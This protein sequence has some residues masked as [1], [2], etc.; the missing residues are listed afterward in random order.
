MTAVNVFCSAD[1]VIIATDGLHHGGSPAVEPKIRT[2]AHMSMALATRGGSAALDFFALQMHE[3]FVDFDEAAA[4]IEIEFPFMLAKYLQTNPGNDEELIFAG[5]SQAR[6]RCDAYFIRGGDEIEGQFPPIRR[7]ELDG[8][9]TMP[10]P[11]QPVIFDGDI[12]AQMVAVMEAQRAEW[13]GLI[14]AFCQ[15]TILMQDAIVQR[16]LARWDD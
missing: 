5:Y 7:R 1:V 10:M 6:Q 11:S 14:G 4:G 13:P 16:I 3:R 15:V 9:V 12:A 2:A 8:I